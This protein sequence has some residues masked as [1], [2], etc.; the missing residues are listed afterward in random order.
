[1][2]DVEEGPP[3]AMVVMAEQMSERPTLQ[4]AIVDCARGYG[5][6]VFGVLDTRVPAKRYAK[7][8]PDLVLCRVGERLLE[9]QLLFI[10]TK[11]QGATPTPEQVTWLNSIKRLGDFIEQVI[12]Y[13]PLDAHIWRPLD[14][15]DG[16]VEAQLERRSA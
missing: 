8:F 6:L 2:I 15:L 10:E 11:R 1:M 12:G 16:T 3:P 4:A 5:W 13:R 14:W 9:S 7:G